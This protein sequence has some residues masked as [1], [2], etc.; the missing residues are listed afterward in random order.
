MTEKLAKTETGEGSLL[1]DKIVGC[2]LAG[3]I[4]NAMG[5][6]VEGKTYKEI[7]K[8][9]PKGI[10][11]ILDPSRLESEDD[12]QMAMLLVETY[13]G[14]EGQPVTA[15][16]FGKTWLDRLNG[17]HFFT[18]CMR[19]T[20]DLLRE[21]WDP[22]IIGHWSQVTGSTVMCLEPVG[23]YHMGDRE[24]AAIDALAIS[25]MYQ[26]GL[27]A[28]AASMLAATVAE[29]FR[30]EATVESICEAAIEA[31]PTT[32]LKTFDKRPFKSCRHYLETCMKI[33]GRY[34]DV[35]KARRELYR[36]CLL[37]HHIDPL[38]VWG[39]ALAMF[40]AAGGDVRE[41]AIGGTNIG[42]DSDTIAGRAAMLAG[43]LRGARG[44]PSEW[45]RM[46]SAESIQRIHKNADRL[47]ELMVEKK[48][49]LMERR[50]AIAR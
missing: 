27:D 30:P 36:K 21:G 38:E 15:R 24:F 25:Y 46:F 5:S 23:I 6:P 3:A 22:R 45:V 4:G 26:R 28:V 32:P 35:L 39:L 31:A 42:R 7:D 10:R 9:Y 14:R 37:Y 47:C 34:D 1:K 2:I 8:Q 43:I 12:N 50:Q 18:G 16:D 49:P 13:I 40:K 48:L 44:V 17:H 41:S 11:T 33:A 29:A 19:H 20:Y